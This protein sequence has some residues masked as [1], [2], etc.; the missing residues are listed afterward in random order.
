MG[1]KVPGIRQSAQVK[2]SAEYLPASQLMQ[3]PGFWPLHISSVMPSGQAS[4]AMHTPSL[5]Y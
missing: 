4:Q 5:L 3:V 2:P 1:Q